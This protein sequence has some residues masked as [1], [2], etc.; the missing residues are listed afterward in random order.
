M[1][2][3]LDPSCP[4]VRSWR[5][6]ERRDPFPSPTQLAGADRIFAWE[7][8]HAERCPRCRDYLVLEA[9]LVIEKLMAEPAALEAV[10]CSLKD[11]GFTPGDVGRAL[12]RLTEARP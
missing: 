10:G 4:T 2:L 8:R 5:E 3:R 12:R 9:A 1:R 11:A 6:A 7:A